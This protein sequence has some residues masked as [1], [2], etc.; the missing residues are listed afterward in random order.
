TCGS[1]VQ[2]VATPAQYYKFQN[3]TNGVSG[4]SNSITVVLNTNLSIQAIFG[5]MQTTNFPTPY[6]WL[7]AHGCSNNFETAV[8]SNGANGIPLWQSYISG[9]NPDDPNDELRLMANS[10]IVPG[11][12]V[13][14]WNTV[15]GR[16]YT[17]SCSTNGL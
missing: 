6:C 17:V 8:T 13:L 3:W 7:A 9:L 2:V 14:N 16:V 4:T 10:G 12:V 15:S 11:G 1:S 5:E